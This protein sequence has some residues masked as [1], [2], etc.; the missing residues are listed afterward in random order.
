[1]KRIVI[2][3]S[4]ASGMPLAIH[5]LKMLQVTQDVETH[6]VLSRGAEMTILQETGM[7][8]EDVK[9]LADCVYDND[10]IGASIASGTFHTD[11]M[12][13][14]PCSMKTVAG[15]AHG[16]SDN[17]LLRAC[18]VMIK[19]QRKLILVTR[20]SP[21]SSI[22]LAN[23]LSLSQLHHVMIMPPMLTYYNLP[24]T[25]EDMERHMIGKMLSQF[26]IEVPC[27]KRWQ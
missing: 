12:I 20:E 4:G 21:L 25:I 13:V 7:R 23:L 3:I 5:L 14:V 16:Y 6:L 19:E 22:H 26:D 9:S 1:M 15:I 18:D 24:Q 27:F 11:G 17:L 8:I 10:N 2:G